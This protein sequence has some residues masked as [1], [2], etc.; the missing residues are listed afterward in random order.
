[1]RP[2]TVYRVKTK[3]KQPLAMARL[4]RTQVE[5][6]GFSVSQTTGIKAEPEAPEGC[7]HQANTFVSP[8]KSDPDQLSK[9]PTQNPVGII[10]H[11]SSKQ[12]HA[13]SIQTSPSKS[14][15][16]RPKVNSEKSVKIFDS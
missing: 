13:S 15:R 14:F 5:L 6:R 12:N 8:R 11:P 7:L 4:A 10:R 3:A 2:Q 1:M 16:F 9:E